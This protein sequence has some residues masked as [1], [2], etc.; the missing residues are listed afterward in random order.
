MKTESPV[1]AAL[2]EQSVPRKK[3]AE[4]RSL[5]LTYN[6]RKMKSQQDSEAKRRLWK[7]LETFDRGE[8]WADANLP[9]WVAKPVTNMIRYVRTLKRANL[10]SA[11]PMADYTA[12]S[13]DQDEIDLFARLE[14]GY[15]HVWEAE[16]VPRM[17]RRCIDTAILKGS[18]IAYIYVDDDYIAGKYFGQLNPKNKMYRGAIKIK[19]LPIER[20]FPDPDADDIPS[21][22][23]HIIED[24]LPLSQIKNNKRFQEYSG[25]KLAELK[26]PPKAPN[27]DSD[28]NDLQPIDGDQM[29]KYNILYERY[30][31]EDHR[32]H[33]D[34]TYYIPE[35][36]FFLLRLEDEKPAVYPFVK[37][38][39]EEEDGEFWGHSTAMDQLENQKVINKTQQTASV[40]GTLHQNPQKIVTRE[41]GINAQ[42]MARTS[43]MPGKVWTTNSD[44]T[45]S[46]QNI[47]PPQVPKGL[48]DVE[49]RMKQDIREMSGV[50]EAYTGQSVGSLTTSSGVN[51]LIERATIRD[52]DKMIQ[53][54]EFVEQVSD[55]I[56]L[57]IAYC[58]REKRPVMHRGANGQ[59]EI[60]EYEPITEAQLQ[61]MEWR[62]RCD[63]YAKA[64]STQATRSQQADNLMQMQGQ[65]QFDPPI[66]TPEE[67]IQMK[68]FDL[69]EDILDR[70]MK[71]R[72][73]LQQRS[74]QE[75]ADV[76]VK[77]AQSIRQAEQQGMGQDQ[78]F[79]MAQEMAQKLLDQR[80]QQDTKQMRSPSEEAQAP[81]GVT[82]AQ[83]M[84]AMVQGR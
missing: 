35:T 17:I 32:W 52:K 9:P 44:P 12:L 63:I 27:D 18:S 83:A 56:L 68:D 61:N 3:T 55:L 45:R 10:A 5:I 38:D 41:S 30:F 69:K 23:W 21:G 47:D 24:E 73:S 57:F 33:L 51:S 77:I 29:V 64:P 1:K 34:I 82:G 60:D 20:F 37:L 43:T 49:D 53:I 2:V 31:G 8:Q 6:K 13:K 26:W 15:K 19:K 16:R 14:K 72:V 58:W 25:D 50:N 75:T 40:I 78:A 62:V 39:D 42:D 79:Q 22:K 65:F 81:K 67:W 7:V 46:V 48:F 66:I 4:E 28:D 70:M 80:K 76:F 59:S 71:D 84:A 11:I 54:D 74:I 36:D